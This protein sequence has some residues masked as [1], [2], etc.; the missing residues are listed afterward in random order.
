MEPAPTL[1]I[2]QVQQLNQAAAIIDAA[3]GPVQ[4]LS[5]VLNGWRVHRVQFNGWR[6]G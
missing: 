2:V 6:V 4:Q 1:T 3:V 5:F